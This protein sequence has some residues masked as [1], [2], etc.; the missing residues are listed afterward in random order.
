VDGS[1]SRALP[2]HGEAAQQ[3][4]RSA[5]FDGPLEELNVK[6]QL[7]STWG[8]EARASFCPCRSITQSQKHNQW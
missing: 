4:G 3:N 1:D 7:G 8:C 6:I 5:Q 2:E